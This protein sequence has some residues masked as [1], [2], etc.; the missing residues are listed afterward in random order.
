[1][2]SLAAAFVLAF[3]PAGLLLALAGFAVEALDEVPVFFLADGARGFEDATA[4]GAPGGAAA[5]AAGGG[6]PVAAP[7]GR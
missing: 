6:A 4:G 5:G 1:M 7:F 3:R 2:L